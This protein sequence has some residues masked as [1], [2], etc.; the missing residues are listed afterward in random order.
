MSSRRVYH[1]TPATDVG[2]WEIKEEGLPR[3]RSRHQSKQ[4][5]VEAARRLA[6]SQP[7]GQIII[8]RSDGTIEEERT[9][10]SD[11]HPPAG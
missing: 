8:H 6:K 7:L 3:A 5:A 10:G 11:P 9:Y 4:E 2:E 1:V